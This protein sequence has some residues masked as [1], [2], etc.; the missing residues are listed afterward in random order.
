MGKLPEQKMAQRNCRTPETKQKV[1]D[2]QL[3]LFKQNKDFK[4]SI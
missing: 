4:G 2:I 1:L 3:N